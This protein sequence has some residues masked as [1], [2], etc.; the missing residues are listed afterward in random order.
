M[1]TRIRFTSSNGIVTHSEGL[2]TQSST[3]H[4]DV[5]PRSINIVSGCCDRVPVNRMESWQTE[6]A[7]GDSCQPTRIQHGSQN[8]TGKFFG[9]CQVKEGDLI[10][11]SHYIALPS[12]SVLSPFARVDY[13]VFEYALS[14]SKHLRGSLSKVHR[15]LKLGAFCFLPLQ[16]NLSKRVQVSRINRGNR[17]KRLNP[18]RQGTGTIPLKEFH[19]LFSDVAMSRPYPSDDPNDQCCSQELSNQFTECTRR[20]L[21]HLSPI[22]ARRLPEEEAP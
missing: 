13:G 10:L 6:S 19:A 5:P 18:A 17:A 4:D 15:S 2:S 20:F 8:R 7:K 12:C 21:L 3:R 16:S 11:K 9:K 1:K 14:P 22:S